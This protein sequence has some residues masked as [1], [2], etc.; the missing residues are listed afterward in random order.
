MLDACAVESE[1]RCEE[2]NLSARTGGGRAELDCASDFL[3]DQD[4]L[5]AEE[6]VV[7]EK[8]RGNHQEENELPRNICRQTGRFR[9]RS[10]ANQKKRHGKTFKRQLL[11]QV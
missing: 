11:Q 1:I 5:D 4:D 6:D 2:E 7:A 3:T 10:Q 8:L 9:I